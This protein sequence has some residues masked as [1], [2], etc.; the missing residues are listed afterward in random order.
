MDNTPCIPLNPIISQLSHHSIDIITII[1][2][3]VGC[4]FCGN[5]FIVP[6]SLPY[7]CSKTCAM[8]PFGAARKALSNAAKNAWPKLC[9]Q[10]R[11]G[12]GHNQP[13]MIPK[14]PAKTWQGSIAT[15]GS[16]SAGDN[17]DSLFT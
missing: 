16:T 12:K 11:F 4:A 14:T 8:Q 7:L 6:I 9:F 10:S 15:L 2:D 17:I 13:P 1:S 5:N 3:Y